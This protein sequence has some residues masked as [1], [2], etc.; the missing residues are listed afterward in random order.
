MAVE[1]DLLRDMNF[2][3][4]VLDFSNKKSRKKKF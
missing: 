1:S 2:E 4:I 3:D